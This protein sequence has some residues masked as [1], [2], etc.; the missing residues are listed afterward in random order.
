MKFSIFRTAAWPHLVVALTLGFLSGCSSLPFGLGDDEEEKQ[1]ATQKS[2]PALEVPP[3]L[4]KPETST[5]Y[6]PPEQRAGAVQKAES[7]THRQAQL[8]G[9]VAPRWQGVQRLRDGQ[10]NWLLVNATPEQVW[11]LISKFLKERGYSIARNEPAIGIMETGW[12]ALDD[13]GNDSLRE[14]LQVR[15]EPHLEPGRTEVFL[16]QKNTSQLASDSERAIEMLNRL[17]QF[18]GGNIID[19]TPPESPVNKASSEKSSEPAEEGTVKLK[20]NKE[21]NNEGCGFCNPK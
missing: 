4:N 18:M 7:R 2:L 20:K 14:R 5:T 16:S 21:R 19:D 6:L 3:D 15:V 13:A 17:A 11:P 1:V 8:S 9:R 10:Q 12:K